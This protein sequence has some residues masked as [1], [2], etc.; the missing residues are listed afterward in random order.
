MLD[1]SSLVARTYR[2]VD[3]FVYCKAKQLLREATQAARGPLVFL[4]S[5]PSPQKQKWAEG[6]KARP[7]TPSFH[8]LAPHVARHFQTLPRDKL[9]RLKQKVQVLQHQPGEKEKLCSKFHL[10]ALTGWDF[11]PTK[12]GKSKQCS[13][14]TA[15]WTFLSFQM[16]GAVSQRCSLGAKRESN[17]FSQLPARKLEASSL[18]F[19]LLL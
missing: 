6:R 7:R 2:P 4:H 8:A 13:S 9:F 16:P 11:T 12:K 19:L 17:G 5:T 3:S 1:Y 15:K 18:L 14:R 10:L